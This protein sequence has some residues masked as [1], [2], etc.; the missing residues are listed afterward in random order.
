MDLDLTRASER[1]TYFVGRFYELDLQLLLIELIRPGD[2]V[3]DIGA[4]VGEI[5]LLCSRLVGPEGIIDAFEP[6]PRCADQMTW[7][8]ARNRIGNIRLHRMGLASVETELCLWVPT[9]NSGE[10]SFAHA[11]PTANGAEDVVESFSVAVGIG[12]KELANDPRPV[13]FIKIDVEG[14]ECHVLDGLSRTLGEHRPLVTTEVVPQHL[15]RAGKIPEELFS[16]MRDRG[17]EGYGFEG[18]HKRR[19]YGLTQDL[20]RWRRRFELSL[21]RADAENPPRDVLWVPA[22]GPLADRLDGRTDGRI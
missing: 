20:Q 7:A 14:F 10:G 21:R 12:D 6:N 13:A 11:G 5:S 22:R 19:R 4:N 17:Y 16:M 8:I 15:A 18:Q 9:N 1:F 2:R 3:V